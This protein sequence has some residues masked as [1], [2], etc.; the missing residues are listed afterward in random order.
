MPTTH[1]RLPDTIGHFRIIEKIGEGGMGEVYRARDEHLDRDVAIKVIRTSIAADPSRARFQKEARVLS[2]LNHPNIETIHEFVTEHGVD[3]IVTEYVPGE[4]LDQMLVRGALPEAKLAAFGVQLADGLAAAHAVGVI[5]RDLKPANLRITPDGR[6]KILDFG[7]AKVLHRDGEQAATATTDIREI[8]GTLPYMSPEQLLNEPLD[9]RTDLWSACCVLYEM[10]T[11]RRPFSGSGPT[12]CDGI[13][14]NEP[15]PPTDFNA[16]LSSA[17][18]SI[19]LKCLEKDLGL[20]CGSAQELLADLRRLARSRDTG[21]APTAS[22][23]IRA[24]AVLPL[25]NL[26][27]DA[28]QEYFADGMTE[29]LITELAQIHSLRVISRTSSMHY[30]GTTKTLPEIA[31]ELGVDGIVEGSVMRAGNRARITAQLIHAS[32]RHLW[33]RSYDRGLE[34]VPGLQSDVARAIAAEIQ[35][36]LTPE[37]EARLATV[38]RV[39]PQAYDAYLLARSHLYKMTPQGLDTALE[40]LR[41]ALEKDPDYAPA[42]AGVGYVWGLRAHAGLIPYQEGFAKEKAAATKAIELDDTLAEGHDALA[43]VLAWFEWDWAGGEREYRRAIELNPNYANVRGFYSLF[44]FAMRRQSEAKQQIELALQTDPY[45]SFFHDIVG[46]LLVNE[47]RP[48]EAL[49]PL[50]KAASLQPDSLYVHLDLWQAYH[51]DGQ[52]DEARE[53]LTESFRLLRDEE[54]VTAVERGYAVGG[55]DRALRAA[56][57]TLAQR[58]SLGPALT[59]AELYAVIGEHDRCID[60]LEKAYEERCS[61]LPYINTL[62]M[63]DALRPDPRFQELV[64]RMNFPPSA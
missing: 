27:R 43:T 25:I 35:V 36:T 33:A 18:G 1:P 40:Y 24:I 46:C 44:L 55:Y 19:I 15:P 47:H 42:H 57:D 56:A 9:A 34:D 31:R 3:F 29:A 23:R 12:L 7:I 37:E 58:G 26:S 64:R 28:E 6:L 2:R 8:C 5:H 11:G 49:V 14:H 20:R 54:I 50:Q 10:A 51:H 52:Y 13:L 16:Q 38:R 60:L 4:S 21:A 32:D 61:A 62:S 53:E 63:Y 30:K 45:N 39:D 17:L 48:K 22:G 59:A 41:L